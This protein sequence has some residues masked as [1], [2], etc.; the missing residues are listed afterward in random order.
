[1]GISYSYGHLI[2]I[3]EKKNR[4]KLIEN[5]IDIPSLQVKDGKIISVTYSHPNN[6]FTEFVKTETFAIKGKRLKL[7]S[8][9]KVF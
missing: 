6:D 9:K 3:S 5:A 1:M 7:M 2:L 8:S 4:L